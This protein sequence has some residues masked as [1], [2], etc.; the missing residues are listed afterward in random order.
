MKNQRNATLFSQFILL[1][2]LF[3]IT[4]SVF[5]LTPNDIAI[6]NFNQGVKLFKKSQYAA[7]VEKFKKAEQQGMA[8]PT[9]YYNLASGYYKTA[10]Y[11]KSK[12]YFNKVRKAKEM[13]YLAE[14]NLGLIAEKQKNNK[15]AKKWFLSVN[16]NSENKKL[17]SLSNR[18]LLKIKSLT[19]KRRKNW[20]AYVDLNYGS[21]DNVNFSPSG[22]SSN[23]SDDFFELTA[24]A[25]YLFSGNKSNG[26]QA[27]AF[28]YGINYSKENSDEYD[29]GL[30]IR[31]YHKLNSAKQIQYSLNI[32]KLNYAG[33]EYQTIYKAAVQVRKKLS[34]TERL[35]LR[36]GYENIRSENSVFNYLE[37][38]RHKLRAGYRQYNKTNIK[39]FYYE[40]ESNSRDDLASTSYS[41][42][43][44]TVRGKYT[45]IFNQ[46]WRL[47]GDIAYRKSDY[48]A[49]ANFSRND[50]RIKMASYLDYYFD[51]TAKLRAKIEYTDNS[52]NLNTFEYKR[53]VLSV[54]VSKSF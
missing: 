44:H 9:L 1:M 48:P 15:L 45:H 21:D 23:R 35:Y 43:R 34:K 33:S 46:D 27:E 16:R 30:G 19:R 54:G 36:Y 53:T 5:A 42:T 18:K 22:L 26:W 39:K 31:K 49:L 12:E 41:P 6:S 29:Y 51:K 17:I 40:F 50:S 3:N 28:Y 37:G 38:A 32:S 20:S 4:F 8:S 10:K 52:S 47:T 7:A 25:D 13:R 2:V 24:F 11:N 14:Y